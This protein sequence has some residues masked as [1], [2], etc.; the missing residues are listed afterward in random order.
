[1][2]SILIPIYNQTV[3]S[4][5]QELSHQAQNLSYPFEILCFDDASTHEEVLQNNTQLHKIPGVNYSIL[6]VNIGRS[7]IRNQL[8]SEAKGTYLLFL[9]CDAAIPKPD[10]IATYLKAAALQQV[11]CGGRIYDK[12]PQSASYLLH[13]TYGTCRES[14]V[15]SVRSNQ[16]YRSFMFNN[17][18]IPKK[19]YMSIMLDETINT[20]GHEDSKFGYQLEKRNLP[21]YHID[22]PVVHTGLDKTSDFLH[23]TEQGVYNLC[24]LYK[25][26]GLG[27]QT[28]LVKAWAM[29]RK[30]HLEKA[31]CLCYD[32]AAQSIRKNL[33]S[34]SP[35]LLYL[36]LYKLRIFCKAMHTMA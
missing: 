29:L 22:N 2:L 12:A 30:L 11:V 34:D 19:V 4:L 6:P 16:P 5:V 32:K 31:F 7:A 35:R 20:Y 21:V 24:R 17:V 1:M 36:D 8:A 15:A 26:E 28:S 14:Q 10:F 3:T 25:M 9:D 23:K 33:F 13:W 27:A 18:F